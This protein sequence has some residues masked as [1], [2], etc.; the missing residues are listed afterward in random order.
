MHEFWVVLFQ[1]SHFGQLLNIVPSDETKNMLQKYKQ[2]WSMLKH[3]EKYMKIKFNSDN[4]L[5]L[6]K[7]TKIDCIAQ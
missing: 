5:S 2:I 4:G 7:N 6:K 3:V 1:I